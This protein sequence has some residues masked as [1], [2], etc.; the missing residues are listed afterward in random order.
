M[1][2]DGYEEK[3]SAM[4]L[5]RRP[6]LESEDFS[7]YPFSLTDFHTSTVTVNILINSYFPTGGTL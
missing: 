7:S 3:S 4:S 2:E 1:K 6:E 5:G